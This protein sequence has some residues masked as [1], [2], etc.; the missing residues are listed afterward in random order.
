[1]RKNEVE[2]QL[3]LAE[4]MAKLADHLEKWQDPVLWQ[5]VISDAARTLPQFTHLFPP[6]QPVTIGELPGGRVEGLTVSVSLSDEQKG[7]LATK[8]YEAVKPQLQEFNQFV[9]D[10]LKEMP[11]HR[12]KELAERIDKGEKLGIKRRRGC[13]FVETDGG[14]E[15]YLGL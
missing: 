11:A 4:A 9:Q 14:Y 10:S 6:S 12:L 3:K 1:M 2:A 5:K 15:A 13:I 7:Q 8:V